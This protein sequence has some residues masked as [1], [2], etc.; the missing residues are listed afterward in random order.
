MGCIQEPRGANGAKQERGNMSGG[1]DRD[2]A[3]ARTP[4]R[5]QSVGSGGAS[6]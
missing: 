6:S 3:V 4:P 1:G 2:E 5:S